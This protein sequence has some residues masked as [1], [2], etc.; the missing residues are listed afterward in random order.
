MFEVYNPIR[1]QWKRIIVDEVPPMFAR[2]LRKIYN[3]TLLDS[4]ELDLL[5]GILRF[6]QN[7]NKK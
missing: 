1:K 6:A 7:H 3:R 2:K 4:Q 5:R